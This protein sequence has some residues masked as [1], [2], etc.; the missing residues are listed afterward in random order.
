MAEKS[1]LPALTGLRFLAALSVAV[2]HSIPLMLP[3]QHGQPLWVDILER[4]AGIGMPLF[5]T[6][7]GFVIHYNYSAELHKNPGI[8]TYNFF[9][10]RFARLYPLFFACLAFDL[11][12]S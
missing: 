4:L 6:L 8:G 2:S 10:A 9:I 7:S 11:I 12:W 3:F 5:F 1:E